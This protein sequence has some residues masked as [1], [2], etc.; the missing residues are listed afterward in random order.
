MDDVYNDTVIINEFDTSEFVYNKISGVWVKYPNGYLTIATNGHLGVVKG[1]QPPAD[2][3]DETKDTYVQVLA[4]GAMKLVG[5][6][7]GKVNSVDGVFPGADK[8]I[9]L[10]VEMTKA[11][12]AALED[13]VGSGKYPTVA[14]K[15]ITLKDVYP[16]NNQY[17]LNRPD[18]WPDRVEIDFGSGLYGKR[19]SGTFTGTTVTSIAMGIVGT[20]PATFKVVNMGGHAILNSATNGGFAFGHGEI[21]VVG[22]NTY[23]QVLRIDSTDTRT[24]APYDVWVTYRK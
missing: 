4:D 9:E 21:Y 1:T 22:D 20:T 11:E 2:P 18:L 19:F 23:K 13:P 15:T 10:T 7:L 14:G 8:N 12:F 6:R 24:N 16:E 17:S 3:T 5:D